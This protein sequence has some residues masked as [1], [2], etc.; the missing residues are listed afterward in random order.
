MKGRTIHLLVT[1]D[2]NYIR[3]FQVMLRSLEINNPGESFH[4][5][6]LHSAVS[7]P[8]L[9]MLNEYCSSLRAA[10]TAIQVD[11]TFFENAPISKQYPQEMYYRLLAPLLLPDSLERILYLDPDI[12]VINPVRP[13]WELELGDNIFAAASHTGL[14]DVM[15]DVN[16][17]R[18][19]Q[20]HDYFNSGVMLM[21][22][23][24]A[25]GIVKPQ[26]IF[27]CVREHQAELVLPDQDVFNFL[28]GDRTLQVDDAVWNY[29]ARY[30]S[31]YLLRSGGV[32]G[33][34]WVM[35]HTVFL[36]FCGRQKP[37]RVHR[38][39]RF[40]VLYKHYMNLAGRIY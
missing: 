4:V 30:F 27:D 21:D 23:E 28:Y 26:E 18:L 6:L 31:V 17:V 29:D 24:R 40:A 8:D 7:Q 5:W 34:D 22:L 10:F 32:C 2:K 33:L 37:W 16:R 36:H 39:G 15:N 13:L 25:R 35:E 20:D 19:K 1:F 11:R 9:R 12:L 3:P 38:G 14:F